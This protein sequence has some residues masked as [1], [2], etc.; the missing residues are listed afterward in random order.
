M[1]HTMLDLPV[2]IIRTYQTISS[3]I[4]RLK[5]LTIRANDDIELWFWADNDTV[6]GPG[7]VEE[8]LK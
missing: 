3:C 2:P 5:E 7:T 6:K 1:A 4:S 8:S